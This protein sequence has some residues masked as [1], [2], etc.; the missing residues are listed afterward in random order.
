MAYSD[1]MLG[2]LANVERFTEPLDVADLTAGEAEEFLRMMVLIRKVE[3]AVADLVVAGKIK[4]PCHLG[5]GQE[6]VATGGY[7][8]C[9]T[10]HAVTPITS[11]IVST[12]PPW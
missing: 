12:A 6:A 2:D 11:G 9:S 1:S 10:C 3:E 4:T 5:I 7:D 8:Q